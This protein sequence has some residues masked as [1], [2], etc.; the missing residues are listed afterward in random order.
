MCK[1]CSGTKKPP[2]GHDPVADRMKNLEDMLLKASKWICSANILIE[3]EYGDEDGACS[4]A[5][6][7][8]AE[9]GK[10]LRGES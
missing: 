7:F 5:R 8:I 10:L 6:A 9:I 3:N 2:V 4:N 1:W